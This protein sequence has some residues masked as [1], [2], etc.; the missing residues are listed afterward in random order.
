MR[1]RRNIMNDDYFMQIA[2]EESKKGDWPYGAVLVK[3][4][5]VVA[6]AFN[7]STR[8][9]DMTAHAEVNLIREA[10]KIVPEVPSLN[11]YTLY[12]SSESCPM[13]TGAEIWAGVS[14]VVY[15]AS[16]QQLIEI[17]QPQI[18]ISSQAI[19][20]TGFVK[21]ELKGGVLADEALNVI[22][23][24]KLLTNSNPKN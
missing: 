8:D 15:G 5:M 4:G 2:I 17:G 19:I 14:R 1:H 18:D 20:K 24:W 9:Q 6:K 7:T 13:C 3:D 16:I 10:S 22:K 23:H 12:T 21:I 11:G